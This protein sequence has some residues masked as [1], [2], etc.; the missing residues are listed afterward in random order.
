MV[1][2]VARDRTVVAARYKRWRCRTLVSMEMPYSGQYG[3]AVLWSVWRCRT[4]VS[5][6]TNAG[7]AVLWSV[8]V[9]T[10]EM[11]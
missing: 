6:G 7:D 1:P 9:Q 5:C 10:L 11:P 8:A 4:L 3:D 2:V